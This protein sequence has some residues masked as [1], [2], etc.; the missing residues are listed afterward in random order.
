MKYVALL[1]A[2]VLF[3]VGVTLTAPAEL[4]AQVSECHS[5]GF[6]QDIGCEICEGDHAGNSNCTQPSCDEC[7]ESGVSCEPTFAFE[8][9]ADGTVLVQSGPPAE[10]GLES[11]SVA[12]WG[13]ESDDAVFLRRPCDRSVVERRYSERAVAELESRAKLLEIG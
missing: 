4:S 1:F 8:F 3:V 7:K 2:M 5:C 13:I 11:L 12:A 6:D 10:G 9:S